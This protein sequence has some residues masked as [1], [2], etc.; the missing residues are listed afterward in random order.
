MTAPR[1]A[2]TREVAAAAGVTGQTVLR[3]SERGLLPPFKV[4]YGAKRGKQSSWPPWAPA[5][6]QWVAAQLAEGFNFDEILGKLKAGEFQGQ[7]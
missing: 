1:R 2:S 4:V 7:A 5:Q 6:A 3:W